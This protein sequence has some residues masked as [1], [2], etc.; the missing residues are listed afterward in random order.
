[1]C[2]GLEKFKA[3]KMYS[4]GLGG[5]FLMAVILQHSTNPRK[6]GMADEPDV[7]T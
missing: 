2:K 6:P 5:S 1:M 3:V 7:L 4:K